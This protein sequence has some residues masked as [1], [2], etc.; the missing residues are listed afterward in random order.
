MVEEA[1]SVVRDAVGGLRA[2]PPE[3]NLEQVVGG[4]LGEAVTRLPVP[5][6]PRLVVPDAS[7]PS[8]APPA[9]PLEDPAVS[10]GV[11]HG[12]P[13]IGPLGGDETGGGLRAANGAGHL[14]PAGVGQLALRPL[15]AN[16]A[17]PVAAGVSKKQSGPDAPRLPR[18]APVPSSSASPSSG[19]QIFVPI[20]AL[21]A[22]LALA[23]PAIERR[24]RDRGGSAPAPFAC[25]L[26]RPG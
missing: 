13:G 7:S 6:A 15:Q 20:A 4:L 17:T 16:G 8:P 18:P 24:L 19:G 9:A 22:L 12:E 3:S 25:A 21:L 26:E 2:L 5:A 1:P 23:A 10:L 11:D 14:P